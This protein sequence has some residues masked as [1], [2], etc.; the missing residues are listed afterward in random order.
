VLAKEMKRQQ[1]SNLHNIG[2]AHCYWRHGRR[3]RRS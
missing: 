2:K 1:A 3:F